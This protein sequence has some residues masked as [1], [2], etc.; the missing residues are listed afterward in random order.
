MGLLQTWSLLGQM[1]TFAL[2]RG[3][4]ANFG[5]IWC[6]VMCPWCTLKILWCFLTTIVDTDTD[7]NNYYKCGFNRQACNHQIDDVVANEPMLHACEQLNAWLG[8]FE[9]ISKRMV[10]G[11]F[12]WLLFYH[13]R[14]VIERQNKCSHIFISCIALSNNNQITNRISWYI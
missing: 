4:P 6:H 9:N 3:C 8:G 14:H 1:P 13:T 5:Y 2:V 10:S 12:D 11:N 7:G